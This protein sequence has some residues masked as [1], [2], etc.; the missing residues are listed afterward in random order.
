MLVNSDV[1][2]NFELQSPDYN[3]APPLL[4]RMRRP[5]DEGTDSGRGTVQQD[6]DYE[7]GEYNA[8]YFN[9]DVNN[10]TQ[11]NVPSP[12]IHEGMYTPP[13]GV[14]EDMYNRGFLEGVV[15]AV[16]I[17][18]LSELH[19]QVHRGEYE[20]LVPDNQYY[21]HVE[22]RGSS[23]I[24]EE[25]EGLYSIPEV[26]KESLGVQA[27][28]VD[29]FGLT[30]RFPS[31]KVLDKKAKKKK[32]ISESK[33]VASSLYAV[34]DKSIKPT[35][36]SPINPAKQLTSDVFNKN[37]AP[38]ASSS[39]TDVIKTNE[40]TE[41]VDKSDTLKTENSYVS[42]PW[43]KNHRGSKSF[44]HFILNKMKTRH[45]LLAL[46]VFLLIGFGIGAYFITDTVVTVPR[47]GRRRHYEYTNRKISPSSSRT[48]VDTSDRDDFGIDERIPIR[49]LT[50][51]SWGSWSSWSK[52]NS[53][54]C[55]PGE[56]MARSRVCLTQEKTEI[57]MKGCIEQGGVN[58]E[59]EPCFC[60]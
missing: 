14:H 43:K 23:R 12:G 36:S 16:P 21:E 57:S 48:P 28:D 54:P 41:K 17:T 26:Q 35:P 15:H 44:T 18:V 52:C 13:P 34:P 37:I 32:I 33:N 51:D 3:A 46:V 9:G 39:F 11:E 6:G 56:T 7:E 10:S 45:R 8:G 38:A 53:S 59:I 58:V 20:N 25:D 30:R 55:I 19:P 5:S 50:G 27:L 42:L 31:I 29:M 40:T 1:E 22:F 60:F 2:M 49:R 4:P 47:D 24:V